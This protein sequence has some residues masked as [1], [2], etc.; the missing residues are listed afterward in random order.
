MA[1]EDLSVVPDIT[2]YEPFT[3]A[4]G[5]VALSEAVWLQPIK[6][7][8]STRMCA[9]YRWFCTLDMPLMRGPICREQLTRGRLASL[10]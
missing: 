7:A 6:N 9:R 2:A 8:I 10:A 5:S 3:R 1:T 4:K